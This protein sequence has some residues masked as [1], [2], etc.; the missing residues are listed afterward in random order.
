MLPFLDK[1]AS[2][3]EYEIRQKIKQLI[4]EHRRLDEAAN[5]MARKNTV[6]MIEMQ[7]LKKRKLQLKDEIIQLE[8]M[9]HPDIPA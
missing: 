1:E 4:E 7:R 3:D 9:L 6:D 8:S 5:D 2:M